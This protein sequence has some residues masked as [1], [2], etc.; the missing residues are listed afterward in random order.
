MTPQETRR[1]DARCDDGQRTASAPLRPETTQVQVLSAAVV[2]WHKV[3]GNT[4][5]IRYH[6]PTLLHTKSPLKNLNLKKSIKE[7]LGGGLVANNQC[8]ASQLRI[9]AADSTR[10]APCYL[11]TNTVK[12]SKNCSTPAE[13]LSFEKQGDDWPAVHVAIIC[14]LKRERRYI[15]RVKILRPLFQNSQNIESETQSCKHRLLKGSGDS[16]Q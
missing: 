14:T 12:P 10:L 7:R 15:L 5:G 6:L 1:E 16:K 2:R 3:P 9:N 8:E 13:F 11:N 4:F